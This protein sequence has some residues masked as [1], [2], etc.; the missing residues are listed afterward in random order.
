MG[1]FIG[2][3]KNTSAARCGL[4][5]NYAVKSI[6]N[7]SLKAQYPDVDYKINHTV[8]IDTSQLWVARTGVRGANDLVWVGRA[9]NYAAKLT[10]LNEGYST[11]ITETVFKEMMDSSKYSTDG[12]LMWEERSWADINMTVYRS[13]FWWGV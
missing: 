12:R 7:P 9:A 8:G 3:Q 11:W 2:N 1:I 6:I 4:K 13:N 10:E 5:I